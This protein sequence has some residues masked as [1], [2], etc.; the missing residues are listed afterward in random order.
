MLKII[1]ALILAISSFGEPSLTYENPK[2][3]NPVDTTSVA[4]YS[5]GD[6]VKC[7]QWEDAYWE[8]KVVRIMKDVLYQIQIEHVRVEGVFT[9]YLNASKCT[10]KKRLSFEDGEGFYETKIWV[11]E[12]CLD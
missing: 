1:C 5:V 3:C 12:R 10:G 4:K 9:V 2:V 6:K 8:G 11:H 7:S